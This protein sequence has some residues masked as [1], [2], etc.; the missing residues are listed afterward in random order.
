[1][2]PPF[3]HDAFSAR[4]PTLRPVASL[5]RNRALAARFC[6]PSA[7]YEPWRG[8]GCVLLLRDVQYNVIGDE[9]QDLSIG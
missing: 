6:S 2:E 8:M 5:P 7:R 4:V 3:A 9:V 1:M